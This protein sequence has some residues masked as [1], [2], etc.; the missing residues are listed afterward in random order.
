MTYNEEH[1]IYEGSDFDLFPTHVIKKCV[2]EDA[3]DGMLRRI[4]A[5]L[6]MFWTGRRWSRWEE[7]AQQWSAD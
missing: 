5:S 1:D 6:D 3:Q 4:K 2:I 7:D